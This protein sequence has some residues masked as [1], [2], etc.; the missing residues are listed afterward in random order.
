MKFKYK[1]VKRGGEIM[2]D[3]ID[4]L[5]KKEVLS[6]LAS[7]KLSP[8]S[9][10]KTNEGG[11]SLDIFNKKISLEDVVFITKY[12]SLMLKVGTDLF[13]AIDILIE[14][15]DKP[16]VRSFLFEI[17]KNLEDG[18]PF[19]LAF[20]KY[21]RTFSPV[22]V[23]LIKSGEVSGNLQGVFEQLSISIEKQY[24]L[25]KKVM[26]SLT[27][28]IIL[29]IVSVLILILVIS[30]PLPKV[31]HVFMSGGMKVPAFSN[32][33]FSI[34]LFMG[35]H[36]ALIL[37]FFT[38]S[39][40]GPILFFTKTILGKRILYDIMLR[41]PVIKNVIVKTSL[42]NFASTLSSLLKAGVSIT[43]ALEI[44]SGSV[45]MPEMKSALVRISNE[46]LKKG[47]TIGQAFR[48][49]P[50]FPK[51]VSNI[52]SISESSGGLE[53]VLKTLGDF[54]G[55]EIESSLKTLVAFIEPVMLL[56]IG[57]II[58]VI[59]LAVILPVYQLASS[60]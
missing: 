4:L 28:P 41:V 58:G 34:G 32:L 60:V 36:L 56:G 22:F 12:L 54:Y 6:Y 51:V 42:Q 40:V 27:Y 24:E 43:E 23:N 45:S 49:E 3:E 25:R 16:A 18:K 59:A 1:A 52:I 14:D 11:T 33:V 46:G 53:E 35:D 5:S 2:E 10:K 20:E 9:I 38:L 15:F 37:V 17:R 50:V 57:V 19:Y 26:S 7:K 31:A 48:R 8:L 44:T 13:K 39:I 30:Y 29:L 21:P 47:L 55:E